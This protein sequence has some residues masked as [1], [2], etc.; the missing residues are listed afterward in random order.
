MRYPIKE[1]TGQPYGYPD[2]VIVNKEGYVIGKKPKTKTPKPKKEEPI[3]K[4]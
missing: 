1:G 4:K 3:A 2:D